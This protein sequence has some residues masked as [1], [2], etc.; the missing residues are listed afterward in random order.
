MRLTPLMTAL[1]AVASPPATSWAIDYGTPSGCLGNVA[2]ASDEPLFFSD[3]W[4]SGG[5]WSCT[6]E[7]SC[8]T[9]SGDRF[10]LKFTVDQTA[11][12]VVI[13]FADGRTYTLPACVNPPGTG[14]KPAQS[15]MTP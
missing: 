13:T 2:G 6:L 9:D 8:E 15:G 4:M 1:A 5:D 7:G 3:D 12:R 11:E 10:T 14:G